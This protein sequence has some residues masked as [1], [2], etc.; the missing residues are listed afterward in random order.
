[1][2]LCLFNDR[3]KVMSVQVQNQDGVSTFQLLAPQTTKL[4]EIDL[5]EGDIPFIKVWETGQTLIGGI[6]PD[7]I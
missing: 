3:K 5:K 1:M 2:K 7:N 4:L 6:N